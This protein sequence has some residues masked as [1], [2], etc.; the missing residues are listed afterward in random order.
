MEFGLNYATHQW[1]LSIIYGIFI[2]QTIASFRHHI[3]H[4]ERIKFYLP[5]SLMVV[6]ALVFGVSS[7][8]IQMPRI[9]ITIEGNNP[10]FLL[11]MLGDYIAV[12]YFQVVIADDHELQSETID[13]KKIYLKRK[14]VWVSLL[15]AYFTIALAVLYVAGDLSPF[16]YLNMIFKEKKINADFKT[17]F[18]IWFSFILP[19][20]P[21]YFSNKTYIF[22]IGSLIRIVSMIS[23]LY[24]AS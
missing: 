5:Y 1:I 23:V 18:L 22:V 12:L 2:S 9:Y 8:Y 19:L 7:W 20:I 3:K 15:I 13:L 4:S 14:K 6:E 21:V 11:A 16:V 10:L 17:C 24:S